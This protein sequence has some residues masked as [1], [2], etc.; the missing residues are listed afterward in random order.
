V[1]NIRAAID[2]FARRVA[3]EREPE[4][5]AALLEFAHGAIESLKLGNLA[6]VDRRLT[7]FAYDINRLSALAPAPRVPLHGDDLSDDQRRGLAACGWNGAEMSFVAT[8]LMAARESLG[9]YDSRGIITSSGR[10]V[11][12]QTLRENNAPRDP[13]YRAKFLG[14]LPIIPE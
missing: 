13:T 2:R 9:G 7:A 12:R 1:T 6:D 3:P 14:R 8:A 11:S 10:R 5:Q 4:A